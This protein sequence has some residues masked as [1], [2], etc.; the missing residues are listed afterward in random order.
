M[1]ADRG[2][3]GRQL[4]LRQADR[5]ALVRRC[6]GQIDPAG[7]GRARHAGRTGAGRCHQ[8][9]AVRLRMG[10][11]CR[12]RRCADLLYPGVA[13]RAR[14]RRPP[15]AVHRDAASSRLSADG[16]C[17]RAG[18]NRRSPGDAFDR[19]GRPVEAG[20]TGGRNGGA[21]TALRAGA[22]GPA[23]A[24]LRDRRAWHRQERARRRLHRPARSP[25]CH[26]RAGPVP[27]SSRCRRALSAA[28]RSADAAGS[29]ARRRM[30]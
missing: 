2:I 25:P 7:R 11:S 1:A 12:Q 3:H 30:W 24:R 18:R 8:A 16:A 29:R 20:R 9:G 23:P 21:A 5:G 22:H 28:D 17:D 26:G 27:R 13:R 15:A 4:P 10:R 14:R 6:R 19:R